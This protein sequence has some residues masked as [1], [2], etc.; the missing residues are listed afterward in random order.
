MPTEANHDDCMHLGSL[1]KA[2]VRERRVV[3]NGPRRIFNEA[4]VDTIGR[5]VRSKGVTPPATPSEF[6]MSRIYSACAVLLA[7]ANTFAG[8]KA[9]VQITEKTAGWHPHASCAHE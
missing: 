6:R 5:R 9:A 1:R 3:R 8:G 4:A 2:V 7:G